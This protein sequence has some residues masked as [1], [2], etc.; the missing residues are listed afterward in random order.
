MA[1]QAGVV[2]GSGY[3][4]AELLR[5]LAGHPDI[6]VVHV[7]AAS[8]AGATVGVAV[9]VARRRRTRASSTCPFDPVALG[10][11][12]LAFL[13]LPHGESQQLVPRARRHGPAPGRPR[14]RLPA[15]GGGATRSG[16]ARRTPRRSCSTASRS[17][18]PSCSASTIAE[19]AHVASPGCYPTAVVARARAAR[20]RR[21]GRADRD[22]RRRDVRASP[23]PGARSST[24]AT[25]PRSTRTSARTACS[26]TGTP[27]RWSSRS[28]QRRRHRRRRCCSRRTSS[29]WC[30]ASTPPATP[31][32]AVERSDAPHRC[33]RST[34]STTRASRSSASSTTRRRPR[35]TTGGNGALRDRALRRA[36]RLGPRDRGAR[37]PREG[38]VGPGDP[39]REP[40][41]SA[42]PRTPASS[43]IGMWP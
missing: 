40:R 2:G 22:H 36:H 28:T 7:T 29:R 34:A 15:A 11:L 25:S 4:G 8:N 31:G 12:D 20:R 21:A 3:T 43:A 35:P 1:Y 42:S 27:P 14:R 30:G 13:A 6:D 39:E 37:Q 18:C 9:P 24:R 10:E 33:S 5:L 38:R 23:V 19:H 16:T 32:P 17:A 41:C 26:R